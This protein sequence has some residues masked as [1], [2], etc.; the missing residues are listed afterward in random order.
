MARQTDF[1]ERFYDII[2][3]ALNR[4]ENKIDANTK[5]TEKV[6]QQAELTNSRTNKLEAE[7]F[8]KVK[9]SDLPTWYR[10][11]KVL[12]IVFNISLAVLVLIIAA[13]KV[14]I[15]SITP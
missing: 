7:V 13:T 12:S 4:L 3:N 6:R 11:P 2:Q 1:E 5:L 10:D 14:D 9:P 8:G 15:S